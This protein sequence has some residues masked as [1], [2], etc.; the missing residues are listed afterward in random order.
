MTAEPAASAGLRRA[1]AA[2]PARKLLAGRFFTP[3]LNTRA[4]RSIQWRHRPSVCF[5]PDTYCPASRK[6]LDRT[7]R[8]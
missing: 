1:R 3:P 7:P 8:A 4:F 6:P 5:A 2:G